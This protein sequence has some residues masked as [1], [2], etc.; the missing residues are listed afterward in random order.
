[1]EKKIKEMEGRL[2]WKIDIL[3]YSVFIDRL[4]MS[5]WV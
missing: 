4:V 1:M 2:M 5:V 3:E